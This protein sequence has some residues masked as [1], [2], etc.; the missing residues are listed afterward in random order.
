MLFSLKGNVFFSLG[1]KDISKLLNG[2]VM[3]VCWQL[4]VSPPPPKKMN[5]WMYIWDNC[6]TCALMSAPSATRLSTNERKPWTQVRW[7]QFRP[8]GKQNAHRIAVSAVTLWKGYDWKGV[9]L[10]ISRSYWNVVAQIQAELNVLGWTSQE[11]T[12]A[13]TPTLVVAGGNDLS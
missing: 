3:Y 9:L 1:N 5:G 11:H 12:T 10:W 8:A 6:V 4:R 13:E 7:R 2:S